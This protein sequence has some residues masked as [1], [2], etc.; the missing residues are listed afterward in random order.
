M[1]ENLG[2]RATL[3]TGFKAPTSGQLNASN[4][5]TLIDNG[6]LVNK[7]V[8]PA[9]NAV[10]AFKGAVDLQ[11]EESENFTIGVFG[12]VGEID[13]TVDYFN[14]EV[15]DRLTLSKDFTLTAQ[16]ITDLASSGV[17]GADDIAKFRFFTNDF[18]TQTSG[19][20]IVLSTSSDWM[21]GTTAWNLAYNHT[22]TEITSRGEY[23][24]DDRERAIEEMSPDTRY[25]LSA[26]HMMDGWRVLGRVS[27]YSDW[28]DSNQDLV[29]PGE[30]VV[31][32]ELSYDLNESSSIMIGGNNVFDEAGEELHDAA[33][34]AGNTFSEFAPMG[35]SGAFWYAKYSYNF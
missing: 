28:F 26:N 34:G 6:V 15:T 3:S 22:E 12:S 32:V 13:F 9:T 11:P 35:F 16:E 29:Y 7:G 10:A 18:D 2:V 17:S 21:N 19:Y 1:D 31:D 5:S 8:I 27:Y 33:D 14:I 20:D 23:I 4:I 24:D 30:Y 25:N